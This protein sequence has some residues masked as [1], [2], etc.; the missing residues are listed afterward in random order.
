MYSLSHPVRPPQADFF[1]PPKGLRAAIDPHQ[2]PSPIEVVEADQDDWKGR[3]YLT[4]PGAQ[5]P[6]STTDYV[7]I[8]QGASTSITCE[9]DPD[10]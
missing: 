2:I 4:L 3:Q 7:A 10:K 9:L 5:V 6:L 1:F 8:D